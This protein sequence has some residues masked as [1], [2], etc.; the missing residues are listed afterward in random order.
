VREQQDRPRAAADPFDAPRGGLHVDVGR[1]RGGA[2]HRQVGH[3]HAERVAR[4][5]RP[6]RRVGQRDL[7]RRVTGGEVDEELASA[8]V[9]A[10]AV[11]QSDQ[12]VARHGLDRAE[13]RVHLCLAVQA[14]RARHEPRRID[15]VR[16]AAFVDEHGC[17]RE[18]IAEPAHATRVIEMD[19]RQD[20]LGE[21]VR[22]D[23]EPVEAGRDRLDGP[24]RSGL[25]ERRAVTAHE[26]RGGVPFAAAVIRVDRGD[27]GLHLEGHRLHGASVSTAALASACRWWLLRSRGRGERTM[28]QREGSS[29]SARTM[30]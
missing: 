23:A 25:D 30:W 18:P 16:G 27:P 6:R 19:V 1:R 7:M 17:R 9:D 11:G 15:Q 4:E 24:R 8:D 21:V 26:V 13:E 22:T 10:V 12:A 5:H 2:Q 28:Q 14:R 3:V 29:A 20:D